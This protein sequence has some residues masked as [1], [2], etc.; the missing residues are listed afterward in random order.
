LD[1][2]LATKLTI[3]WLRAVAESA[4]TMVFPGK[5]PSF[6]GQSRLGKGKKPTS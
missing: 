2:A 3:P 4:K 1:R 6:E 5:K